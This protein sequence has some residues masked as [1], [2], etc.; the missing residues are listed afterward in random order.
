MH[1]PL[2]DTCPWRA[3]PDHVAFEHIV[4]VT[5]GE[6]CSRTRCPSSLGTRTMVLT[7][8]AFIFSDNRGGLHSKYDQM[9]GFF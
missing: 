8:V 5:V 7:I 4:L 9:K 1:P 3:L 2:E 6:L